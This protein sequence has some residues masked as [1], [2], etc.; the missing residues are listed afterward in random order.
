[1]RFHRV[2]VAALCVALAGCAS[3]DCYFRLGDKWT[4]R[5]LRRERDPYLRER[6][7]VARLTHMHMRPTSRRQHRKQVQAFADAIAKLPPNP[8]RGGR[9][10]A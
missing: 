5:R 7:D 2:L 9:C 1:M 3:E 10:N 6:V 8:P 4:E